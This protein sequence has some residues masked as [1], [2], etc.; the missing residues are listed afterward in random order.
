[1]GTEPIEAEMPV[2]I[3]E[4]PELVQSVM[5][6]YYMLQDCWDSMGGNYLGKN[7]GTLFEYFR[8]FDLTEN[9]QLLALALIQKMDSVRSGIISEKLKQNKEASSRKKA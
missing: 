9:E 8:L 2:E 4:F 7:T 5:S 1:M 3:D 6:I